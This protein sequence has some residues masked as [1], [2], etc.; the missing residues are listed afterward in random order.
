M[1]NLAV[2]HT[3]PEQVNQEAGGAHTDDDLRGL[4]LMRL[5]KAL[6]GLQDDGEAERREEDG[7]DQRA[8]HLG[9][10]PAERVLAG[11]LRPAGEA[12]GHQRHQQRDHVRQH[13]E[14][15]GKHGQRRREPAHHH[16]GH[17]E[18]GGQPQHAHQSDA[19]RLA[20]HLHQPVLRIEPKDAG[21]RGFVQ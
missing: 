1:N 21:R 14:G 20:V 13:V 19:V 11:G 17:E 4:D 16:L 18:A 8:H 12:H 3:E 15:V 10:D 6:H 7:V 5:S 9:A 2:E